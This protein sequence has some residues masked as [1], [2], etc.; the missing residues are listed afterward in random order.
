MYSSYTTKN[1]CLL[2]LVLLNLLKI[3]FLHMVEN[4]T[5]KSYLEGNVNFLGPKYLDKGM[6]LLDQIISDHFICIIQLSSPNVS[7]S[8]VSESLRPHGL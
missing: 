5:P 1:L 4:L 2:H 3:F 8:I 6:I 7:Q